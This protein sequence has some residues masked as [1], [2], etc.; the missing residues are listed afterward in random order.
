MSSVMDSPP[1]H[2]FL[3]EHGDPVRPVDL[4]SSS[5]PNR[6]PKRG[7]I[8]TRMCEFEN[9]TMRL[10]ACVSITEIDPGYLTPA[11]KQLAKTVIDVTR[12][13]KSTCASYCPAATMVR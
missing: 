3:R 12:A 7:T 2:V 13:R 4:G 10:A 1:R 8:N 5:R 11:V 6:P 9:L